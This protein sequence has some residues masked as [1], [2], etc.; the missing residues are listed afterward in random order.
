M[1]VGVQ[2]FTSGRS[3][4]ETLLRE[5]PTPKFKTIQIL[6][7]MP[8]KRKTLAQNNQA[9]QRS[10]ARLRNKMSSNA[11]ATATNEKVSID[12]STPTPPPDNKKKKRV[13]TNKKPTSSGPE[14]Q[15]DTPI[16]HHLIVTKEEDVKRF[17]EVDDC[18]ILG[19]D[20]IE[21]LNLRNLSVADKAAESPDFA[22]VAEK[23][24]VWILA[25]TH[26]HFRV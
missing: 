8:P 12:L 11:T 22:I 18:F 16:R 2:F 10:S 6:P 1:T 25:V 23:G 19:F 13:V 7:P 15:D 17:E 26:F 14:E 4:E 24:K 5:K 21:P 20:P 3:E 9:P